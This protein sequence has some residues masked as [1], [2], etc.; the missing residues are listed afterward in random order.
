[1][2]KQMTEFVNFQSFDVTA[3]SRNEAVEMVE[4]KSFGILGDATQAYKNAKKACT[5]GWT[6]REERQFFLNYLQKKAKMKAGVGFMVTLEA[7]IADTRERPY[8]FENVKGE[9]KRKYTT[10]FTVETKSGESLVLEGAKTKNE[11]QNMLKELFKNGTLREDGIVRY[12][13][14]V[15]GDNEVA[16]TFEYTPS[17]NTRKGVY[18]VF[19]VQ[20]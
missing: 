19:G 17:K 3:D 20:A 2:F 5:T 18:R 1:M 11:A 12:E 14:H 10:V 16:F 4:S 6:D 13:K 8:K 7:A 15:E 9:G